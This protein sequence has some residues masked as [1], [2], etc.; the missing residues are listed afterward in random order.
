MG[1]L[2]LIHKQSSAEA[3]AL[4]QEDKEALVVLLQ[5]GVYLDTSRFGKAQVYALKWDVDVRGLNQR[6]PAPVKLIS[7]H[8]LVDLI[9][10]NKVINLT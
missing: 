5:D 2:Y 8:E 3:L 7:Y 10:A 9:E 4:V 1:N 6:M